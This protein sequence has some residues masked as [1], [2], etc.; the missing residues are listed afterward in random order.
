MIALDD[1]IAAGGHLYSPPHTT[2]FADFS[3]DSRL[4]RPGELFLALRTPRADGHDYN[5]AAF[6]AGDLDTFGDLDG[7]AREK[8][9]LVEALPPDGWAVLNGDDS[10]VAAMRERTAARTITFGLSAGC[11][12]RASDIQLALDQTRFRLHW[13]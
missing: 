3:Y 4:A 13:E 10:R 12:L 5:P 8:R 6:A 9:A 2:S 11:D 1:L 7:V